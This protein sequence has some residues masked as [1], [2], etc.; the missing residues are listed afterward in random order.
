MITDRNIYKRGRLTAKPKKRTGEEES[1]PGIHPLNLGDRKDGFVYVPKGY[2]ISRPASLAVML[3]GSGGNPEHGLSYLRKYA[4]EKNIILIAPASRAS[5]WDIIAQE[6]FDQDVIFIDQ[7]LVL[8][9]ETYAIDPSH[10]AVGGFS[11]GASYALSLGLSNGDLF[12]H[13]IAFSPGFAFT[14]EKKGTPAIFVSHGIHDPVLSIDHC[15]RRIVPLLKVQGYRVS[16]QE[17]EGAHEI[18]FHVSKSGVEW[19]TKNGLSGH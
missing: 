19:F 1:A 16:Y 3:H 4:D 14:V 13:I 10:V 8:A 18:P 5:T 6:A 11:D 12:T 7:A 17:F 15:S 2:D 9:F